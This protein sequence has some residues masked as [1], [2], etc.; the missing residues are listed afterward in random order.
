MKIRC[1]KDVIELARARG[2][3]VLLNPGPPPMPVLRRPSAVDSKEVT[4]ALLGAL[5]AWRL[6][7]IEELKAQ[8]QPWSDPRQ[9]E[10]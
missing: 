2:F 9:G 1:A 10:P 3:S 6:E 8:G 4:E 5:R 7:I